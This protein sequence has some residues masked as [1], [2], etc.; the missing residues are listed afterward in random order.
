MA[1][2]MTAGAL[3]WLVTWVGEGA[4]RQV[5]GLEKPPAA[6]SPGDPWR[7]LTADKGSASGWVPGPRGPSTSSCPG[8]PLCRDGALFP[9]VSAPPILLQARHLP[10]TPPRKPACSR[11]LPLR[12]SPPDKGINERREETASRPSPGGKRGARGRLCARSA[13]A[14][15]S[16]V[17]S[18]GRPPRLDPKVTVQTGLGHGV[19]RVTVNDSQAQ[20][21]AGVAR[22]TWPGVSRSGG[23]GTARGFSAA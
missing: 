21:R 17:V 19:I 4:D 6:G 12:V 13:L 7:C 9:I 15:G 3:S 16:G 14:G 2:R 5:Q 20:H 18:V 10:P 22:G 11:G 1:L 23:L 8:R